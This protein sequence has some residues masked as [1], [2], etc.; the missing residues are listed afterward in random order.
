MA[1]QGT[2]RLQ[3]GA[4]A[5]CR[6]VWVPAGSES[7]P[8]RLSPQTPNPGQPLACLPLSACWGWTASPYPGGP[9][10]AATEPQ[11]LPICCGRVLGRSPAD[12]EHRPLWGSGSAE[13]QTNGMCVHNHTPSLTHT[14]IHTHLIHSHSTH[15][16]I[17]THIYI[18]T[19]IYTN[20][21]IYRER[22]ICLKE[23]A[24]VTTEAGNSDICRVGWHGKDLGKS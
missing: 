16:G 3:E 18:Y 11:P 4:G 20:V 13:K 22:N 1:R 5:E 10:P 21:Y 15:S 2:E 12:L 24:C 14:Q 19:C 9:A 6:L 23:L 8:R 7:P 17:Y